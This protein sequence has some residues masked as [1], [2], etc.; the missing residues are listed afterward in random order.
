MSAVSGVT[1][2]SGGPYYSQWESAELV[3]RFI[4][5]SL[6]PAEDPRWA[7]SGAQTPE[8]Y[9]YWLVVSG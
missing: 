2:N 1:G 6:R 7:D 5:G 9:E 8:Q 3:P 4:D